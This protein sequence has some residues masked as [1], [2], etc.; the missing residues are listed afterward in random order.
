MSDAPI[1]KNPWLPIILLG[2]P[3][4]GK[5]YFKHCKWVVLVN[6]LI[7]VP[8][9][10]TPFWLKKNSIFIPVGWASNAFWPL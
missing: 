6:F 8:M 4:F 2:D 5:T 1:L 3:A 9:G 10:A 7:R